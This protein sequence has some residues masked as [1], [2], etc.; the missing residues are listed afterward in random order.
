VCNFEGKVR[1]KVKTLN[2]REERKVRPR[3]KPRM[4]NTI[5]ETRAHTHKIIYLMS[6]KIYPA[7]NKYKRCSLLFRC[8]GLSFRDNVETGKNPQASHL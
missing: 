5:T 1:S 6:V 2:Y 4:H 7:I 3:F 8:N